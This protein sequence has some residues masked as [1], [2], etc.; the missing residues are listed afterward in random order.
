MRVVKFDLCGFN[1]LLEQFIHITLRVRRRR[2][3]PKSH[4]SGALDLDAP[5]MTADAD[6]EWHRAIV[7]SGRGTAT[8]IC[9]QLLHAGRYARLNDCVGSSSLGA[10]D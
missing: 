10:S 3:L 4:S 1:M 8:Y 2:N 6:L 7:D 5:A 9:M